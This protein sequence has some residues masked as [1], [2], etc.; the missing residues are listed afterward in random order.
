HD[1]GVTS[2]L[3][4]S[5]IA[6][7]SE[8]AAVH[9]IRGRSCERFPHTVEAPARGAYVFRSDIESPSG[10]PDL[11]STEQRTPNRPGRR[12]RSVPCGGFRF[13]CD[14]VAVGES[15]LDR[16]GGTVPDHCAGR[17]CRS[18]VPAFGILPSAA[19]VSAENL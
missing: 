4:F 11:F 14:R 17:I 3:V 16:H 9:E 18:V 10:Y 12:G 19:S 8:P 1:G 13:P 5:S 15:V 6:D 7:T 2:Q